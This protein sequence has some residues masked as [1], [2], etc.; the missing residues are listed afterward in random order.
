MMSTMPA[1]GTLHLPVAPGRGRSRTPMPPAWRERRLG[2]EYRQAAKSVAAG[3]SAGTQPAKAPR[4]EEAEAP[5]LSKSWRDTIQRGDR[6]FFHGEASVEIDK[7]DNTRWLSVLATTEVELML[8]RL[9]QDAVGM[10]PVW[11]PAHGEN[12]RLV[13]MVAAEYPLKMKTPGLWAEMFDE[14][15]SDE[16]RAGSVMSLDKI[17]PPDAVF[18][19]KLMPHQQEALDYMEKCDGRCLI[20]DE[21][22]LGKTVETLAYLAGRRDAY[23]VAVV[24][25]LV[26][27]T[28]WKREI[29]RFLR[30]DGPCSGGGRI[31]D[32]SA[33]GGDADGAARTPVIEVIRAGRKAWTGPPPRRADF[34]LINYDLVTK[35]A[36]ALAKVGIR[37]IIFDECQAL[38]HTTSQR[39]GTCRKLALSHTVRHR[40]ALSGTPIFNRRSELHNISEV[41]RPGVLG[42]AFEFTRRWPAVGVASW[43]DP[44]GEDGKDVAARAEQQR[45]DLAVMLRRR[46]MLRRLKDEVIDLPAKTRLHQEIDIDGGYYTREVG[47]LLSRIS[48]ECE[49]IKA[50]VAGGIDGKDADH[51]LEDRKKTGL[52]ALHNRLMQMR[53]AERQIAGV[54]KAGSVSKY[55]GSLLGDYTDDKFVVFCHHKS[56]REILCMDLERFGV[57][58][59]AGGQSAAARQDEIDRF[60]T[61]PTC[62]VMVAGLRAGNV[63]ISLSAASYVVFA[64]LDWSPS[65]HRQAEDR[66]HRIGQK[67]PVV[68]HYLIGRGTFDDVIG[69]TVVRKTL[70]ISGVMGEAPGRVDAVTALETIAKRYGAKAARM[71]GA[72]G[73]GPDSI[74]AVSEHASSIL[75]DLDA[76]RPDKDGNGRRPRRRGGAG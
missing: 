32:A 29:E 14:I 25:P 74:G 15:A 68:C 1:H 76:L 50:G 48:A 11:L 38:R 49:Q 62:R 21:M 75:A 36:Y 60:Q 58:T 67:N 3:G 40:I 10:S 47:R 51:G 33:S 53:I 70:D 46:F 45:S 23:P 7:G 16:E 63:G 66:L 4:R 5:D 20:A 30:V 31:D 72:S 35:W 17:D 28:H 56:V 73:D 61:D 43:G 19:G 9:A 65:V 64:E 41:I 57:A 13:R 42:S 39:Y 37:T 6:T 69:Q 8:T 18:V 12:A 22:G 27:V 24:A 59:I 2:R 52:M 71:A 34:Y 44:D 54:S 26:A 55:V